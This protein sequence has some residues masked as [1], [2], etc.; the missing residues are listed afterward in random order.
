MI[1]PGNSWVPLFQKHIRHA[2]NYG[3]RKRALKV[4]L[5][6]P[7][8]NSSGN[9]LAVSPLGMPR[10]TDKCAAP[11]VAQHLEGP[12]LT[13]R[14]G[15]S[16]GLGCFLKSLSFKNTLGTTGIMVW[17][18]DYHPKPPQGTPQQGRPGC[19][20]PRSPVAHHCRALPQGPRLETQA[21]HS[22]GGPISNA[23]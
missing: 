6:P 2:K 5:K 8:R 11:P 4:F 10:L 19:G 13:T 22:S 20:C 17:D 3:R 1:V 18:N 7:P 9:S 14:A 23:P 15:V 21:G 16:K 12:R